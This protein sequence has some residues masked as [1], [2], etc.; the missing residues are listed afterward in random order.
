MIRQES[1]APAAW[2]LRA[3]AALLP[4]DERE[5]VIGDLVEDFDVVARRHGPRRARIVFWINAASA[6]LAVRHGR[7][8]DA[9]STAEFQGDGPMN[10]LLADIRHVARG[11]ARAP[12]FTLVCAITLGLGIG[13][14]AAMFGVID[15]LVL[16]GPDDI[17]RPAA[18]RR[19]YSTVRQAPSGV[20][21]SSVTG[22]PAY[23]AL[24]DGTHS[25]D[26]V[27]AYE[28]NNWFVGTGVDARL[29]PGIAATAD[30]FPLLG[31]K[32]ALGRF[33]TAAEEAPGASRDVVVLGYEYWQSA[34]GADPGV[35]GRQLT[36]SFH[37]FTVI[38]V[39]PA[40]FTGAALEPVD[41]W[42]PLASSSPP[43]KDWPTSWQSQ[44]LEIVVRVKP[45]MALSQAERD[46]TASFRHAYT[47]THA[48]WR[49][50]ALSLL[51]ISYTSE[52]AEPAVA[53]VARWLA[54]VAVIVLLIA[55]ANVGN[56]LLSRALR[57]RQEIA[58]RAALG[59]SRRRLVGLL[60]AEG[61]GIAVASGIVGIVTAYAGGE[62]IRRFFLADILWTGSP[63]DGR[64]LLVALVLTLGVSMLVSLVPIVHLRRVELV[65][66]LKSGVRDGGGRQ[67][68]V[69]AGLLLVQTT[70][71]VMLL[72]GAG[73]FVRSLMNVRALD[74]GIRTDRVLAASIAFPAAPSSARPDPAADAVRQRQQWEAVRAAVARQSEFTDASLVIGSPFRSAMGVDV[75][76]PGRDSLPALGGGGPYVTPVGRDYFRTVGTRIV[77]GRPFQA[78]EG[79]TTA[80][81][82]IVNETMARTLW[83]G[84][85][86]L[87]KC[88]IVGDGETRCSAVVGVAADAHR[89]SLREEPAMQC[90]LPLGQE[91]GISGIT[92]VVRPRGTMGAATATLRRLL[93][94]L[95]PD[96]RFIMVASLQ[97]SVDPQIRPWRLGVA[98]FGLFGAIALVVAAAG[99]YSVV[100]YVVAQRTHEF[101]IRIALGATS[102]RILRSVLAQGVRIAATGSVLAVVLSLWAG[103]RIQDQ[104]FDESPRDPVVYAIV[105]GAMLLV[106]AM[107][108]LVPAAR[109]A[110]LDAASTLRSE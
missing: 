4:Q 1:S 59:M 89:F 16:R 71:S 98:L 103:N 108:S 82:V 8:H 64:V 11:V 94:A 60:L 40:G 6:V 50:A 47:G 68:R 24:R 46:A 66:A 41:Y 93:G 54:G 20:Q 58:V 92:L 84:E 18:V 35:V 99:L 62:L 25:F 32:P 81:T 76:L 101:G 42:I 70:L 100:A 88:V 10:T 106:A 72:V 44:W 105:I 27:A 36:I 38:G 23:T 85:S 56:L 51:P 107:A 52:G 2:M 17:V 87:G 110:T 7:R 109:A 53:P 45:G 79:P 39:A 95:V 97:D 26:G 21:T 3:V 57:R 55:C 13:A 48:A 73:L 90:Y 77:L 9:T 15:R 37:P 80:R 78:N 28:S 61:L 75:R 31:V 86:P 74:L 34:F 67:N 91:Q 22:Y 14:S 69:R 83:P 65:D 33:Y 104:L 63:V 102:T 96:A 19:V 43:R 12:G 29:L 5:F 30:F 49:D